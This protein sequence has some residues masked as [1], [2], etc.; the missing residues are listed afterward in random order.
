MPAEVQPTAFD[1]F[2]STRDAWEGAG[3][4]LW[5]ARTIT[6]MHAGEITQEATPAGATFVM[7]LPEAKAAD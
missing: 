6:T 3:L 7:R 5:A 2:A 1:A 4:G